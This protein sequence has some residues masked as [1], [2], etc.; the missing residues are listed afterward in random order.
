MRDGLVPSHPSTD[1]SNGVRQFNDDPGA[2][3]LLPAPNPLERPLAAVRRFKWLIAGLVVLAAAA[4]VA[5]TRLITP[6]YE[7]RATV[8]IAAETPDARAGTGPIRSG[9]LLRSGAWIELFRSYRIVDE[10]VRK[11]SL[12]LV[13][14]NREQVPLFAGFALAERFM[15]G[16]YELDIDRA[17]RTWVLKAKDAVEVERGTAADSVGRKV[18][19]QWQLPAA[20]FEG[21]GG[22]TVPFL[23][24]TPRETSINML[25]HLG[26]R[27]VNGSNFLWLTYTSTDATLGA[28]TLNTWVD[29]YVRVA[30]DLKKRNLVEFTSILEGQLQYAERATQD[31]ESAYQRFRIA[32]ITLPTEGGPVAA[33]VERE[34]DP[35]LLSFFEQKIEH[36]NLRHDREALEKSIA[37]AAKASVPYE[38]LL[39][40]PSVAQ[41]PGA[42]ALREAFRN[43]YQLRARLTAERQNF[44]DEYATV[45]E[46]KSTLEVLENT[47][48]PQLANQLL[49]QL[50]ERE[51]D[52]KRR[53][54][55]ASKEL[56]S[57]PPRTIE[58]RRLNRAVVVSEG[59]YT[60]LKARY[61]EAKLAEASAT[62][63][64][65]VLDTAVAP[66]SPTRN[67]AAM[68]VL[69][70][71]MAGLGGAIGLALLIDRLD[72]KFRYADQTV[73][74]LG[75][76]I[77]TAVP[78]MP[79]NGISASSPEQVVQ[80]VESFR[81]LRMHVMHGARNDRLRL[82][83]TS[84]A[85][86]DGKSLVSSNLALSCA[87]AGL[88]TVLIDG[89]TRRG[90]L[91][92][93][94]GLQNK[95]GLTEYLT[96]TIHEAQLVKATSHRNLSFVSCGRRDRNSPELIASPRLK[97]LVEHL[98]HAFDVVIFDTP[99][100]A[101]GIDGYAISAAT[102]NVIMVVRMGHTTRRLASAKLA[103]LDRLP[104]GILGTVLNE[105][106]STGEFQY[107]AYSEGY[108][109]D[110]GE[111][112]GR[113][114]QVGS[115]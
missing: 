57:I 56:Q 74:E 28:R 58:E 62:P 42:E 53:I 115:R 87:E 46:L 32:A 15:P 86:G 48:I 6:Q 40:I 84:A 23:V 96:G 83:V 98:G 3:S 97:G 27:L 65:S 5:G 47:T 44:T 4:G 99:P 110:A 45:K 64:V 11:L 103:V 102:G 79:K 50:R 91:H 41:S 107:Y 95:E 76:S 31:A 100:L 69:L 112:A 66:L 78:R 77:A 73:T 90:T 35:A 18:G 29:E 93:M 105:V 9:E 106:P 17:K 24:R 43:R 68:I 60:N 7:V 10:V 89:D 67:T 80:F 37:S 22:V 30:A 52:Y 108:S 21:S 71:I 70:A 34:R 26:N 92:R 114:A 82:A 113:I 109:V 72:G 51:N 85:P 101:A 104:V 63:D 25:D 20:V 19:F 16:T 2:G 36:D 59:L 49:M 33:G 8:W 88:R 61:A 13:P 54:Q 39:L 94:F 38:G 81:T 75:L 14:L 111:P 12:Y 1:P 55:S